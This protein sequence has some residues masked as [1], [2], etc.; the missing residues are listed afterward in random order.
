MNLLILRRVSFAALL[1]VATAGV[2][3]A[4]S[5]KSKAA[6]AVTKSNPLFNHIPDSVR[7]TFRKTAAGSKVQRIVP[8]G[9]C[10]VGD[11]KTLDGRTISLRVRTDGT[12][13]SRRG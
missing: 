13:R 8:V 7:A 6:V 12:V 11:V 3:S 4:Q 1:L 5:V 10:F 9:Y 2:A